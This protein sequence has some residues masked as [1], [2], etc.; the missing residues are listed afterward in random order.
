MPEGMVGPGGQAIDIDAAEAAFAEAM[1]APAAGEAPEYSAPPRRD[2][3]APY[4]RRVDGT[5]KAKPGQKGRSVGNEKAR[6][7]SGQPVAAAAPKDRTEVLGGLLQLISI[8]LMAVP[9]LRPDAAALAMHGPG[10]VTAL[11]TAASADPRL[12][13]LI[14]RLVTVGPYGALVAAVVPLAAQLLRN[15]TPI[16]IPGT[17]DPRQL[18]DEIDAQLA[19]PADA[20]DEVPA[21]EAA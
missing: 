1:A 6:V 12:G 18:R 16:N 13:G 19:P 8:P 17:I 15:H 20:E 7:R 4:G 3:E 2:P 9:E 14:D 5:P 21:A 11:N 10:V